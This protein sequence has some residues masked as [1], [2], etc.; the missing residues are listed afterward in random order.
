MNPYIGLSAM[1][2]DVSDAHEY[3]IFLLSPLNPLN[4]SFPVVSSPLQHHLRYYPPP[5]HRS[6]SFG[7]QSPAAAGSDPSCATCYLALY[8]SGFGTA[9]KR[10]VTDIS[11]VPII[12]AR[13]GEGAGG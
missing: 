5:T 10:T 6:T 9:G 11:H 13:L 12:L 3:V 4:R 8:S 1:T 2:G 7:S